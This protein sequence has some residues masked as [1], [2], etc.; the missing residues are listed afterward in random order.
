MQK[1]GFVYMM[2]VII[3]VTIAKHM[4]MQVMIHLQWQ[5]ILCIITLV[6]AGIYLALH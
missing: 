2:W 4:M 3:M 1:Y 5:H 6:P